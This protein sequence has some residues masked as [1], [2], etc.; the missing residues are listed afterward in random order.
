[1]QEILCSSL[2][3]SC[4]EPGQN[5]QSLGVGLCDQKDPCGLG[6]TSM[7]RGPFPG[8]PRPP[9]PQGRT[10]QP[11]CQQPSFPLGSGLVWLSFWRCLSLQGEAPQDPFPGQPREPV[12]LGVPSPWV[13]SSELQSPELSTP[14]WVFDSSKEAKGVRVSVPASPGSHSSQAGALL[15]RLN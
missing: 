1:M 5:Y 14:F 2:G 6:S 11:S 13:G 3:I 9:E 4:E 8:G 12:L 10:H 15:H 7:L